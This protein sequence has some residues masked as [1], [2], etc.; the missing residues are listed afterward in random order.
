[1]EPQNARQRN[2]AGRDWCILPGFADVR[3]SAMRRLAVILIVL[4]VAPAAATASQQG[5][6]VMKKW[7]AMDKC[8]E[9]S[10]AAFPDYTTQS[11][12]R[13]EALLRACLDGQNLP[14]RESPPPPAH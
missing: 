13:R 3:W 1:M 11:N 9:R 4:A 10:Y 14:P 6:V 8:T 12:A 7:Q 2:H 5:T